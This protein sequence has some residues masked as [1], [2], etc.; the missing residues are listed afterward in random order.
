MSMSSLQES[1]SG[2]SQVCP[3]C[4]R[5]AA[6]RSLPRPVSLFHWRY[7]APPLITIAALAGLIVWLYLSRG[8]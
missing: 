4:G 8:S 6:D 2:S 7:V 5:E 1:E 3:E